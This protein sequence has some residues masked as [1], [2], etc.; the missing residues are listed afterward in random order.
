[1]LI[2]MICYC[3]PLSTNLFSVFV[4]VVVVLLHLTESVVRK[5]LVIPQD[6]PDAVCMEGIRATSLEGLMLNPLP[7]EFWKHTGGK[8]KK[9]GGGGGKKKKSK[10]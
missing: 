10:K 6:L 1:M 9:G 7:K 8:K 3:A 4:A 5:A 2:L